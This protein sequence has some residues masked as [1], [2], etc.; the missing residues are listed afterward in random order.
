MRCPIGGGIRQSVGSKSMKMSA[1]SCGV[2][3]GELQPLGKGRVEAE[4]S[5]VGVAVVP[6]TRRS[7]KT[8]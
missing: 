4:A 2:S 5:V 8:I 3:A 1:F 7:V 6:L